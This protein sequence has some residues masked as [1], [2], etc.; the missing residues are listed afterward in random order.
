MDLHGNQ[1]KSY[2]YLEKKRREKSKL[3]QQFI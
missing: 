1:K 2:K 3:I